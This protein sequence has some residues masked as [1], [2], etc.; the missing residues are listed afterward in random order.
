[1]ALYKAIPKTSHAITEV[2]TGTALKTLLQVATPSTTD[3]RIVGWGISFDG[4]VVTNPSGVVTLI[5]VDVAATVT[6]LTPE[7]WGAGFNQNSLCVGGASATGYNATAEGSITASTILDGQN[8]HPQS[9]YAL[10]YPEA[11]RPK[12]A[13]S[14]F[15]RIRALFSVD[16]NAIPWIVWQEPA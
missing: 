16:I 1:M 4:V 13:I 8:V 2:A 15:L 9:G 7:K 5:D 11:S 10:W 14:R 3:I 12:I 6:S